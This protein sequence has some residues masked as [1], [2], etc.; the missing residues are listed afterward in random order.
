M[1][2][3]LTEI[4]TKYHKFEDNQVLT[5]DQ[6]NEFLN[7]FEDQDRMS[8]IYLSGVGIVCG[9]ELKINSSKTKDNLASKIN[10]KVTKYFFV[11]SINFFLLLFISEYFQNTKIRITMI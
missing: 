11:L 9:F 6:L 5:K 10:F 4:K 1:A 8:R 7:Y 3:K 2:A